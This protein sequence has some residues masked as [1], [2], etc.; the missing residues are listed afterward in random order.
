M[1]DKGGLN[2][3]QLLAHPRYPNFSYIKE[4]N[5]SQIPPQVH[6]TCRLSQSPFEDLEVVTARFTSSQ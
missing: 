1:T 4:Q 6:F 2:A 3:Q 5:V